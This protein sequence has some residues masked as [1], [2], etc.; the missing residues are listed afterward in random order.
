[1]NVDEL[2]LF[3]AGSANDDKNKHLW[4]KGAALF[5]PQLNKLLGFTD[6][7]FIVHSVADFKNDAAKLGSIFTKYGSDKANSHNYHIV[8]SYIL[9]KLGVD[10]KLD[11]LEIG[12]GTNNPELIS[13]MGANG[14]PGASLYAFREYLPNANIYG[15]DIDKAILFDSERIKTSYVDQLD[16]RTFNELLN[17]FGNTKF[18][19]I[20][21]DGLHS[22]GANLNT[23][24]FALNNL[25]DNG[26]IVIEDIH[27]RYNWMM[28]EFLL[29]NT[30]KYKTHFIHADG[31]N[32]FVI[33]KL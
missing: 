10:S 31:G 18:D 2:F 32:L 23:L 14:K 9:N 33:N 29:I 17:K 4:V 26:W 5:I 19:L 6:Y 27:V 22:I 20:I 13:S 25:K 3:S 1:M 21:D 24:I 11:I 30:N 7:K 12:M 8:Y 15:A 28:I 16:N